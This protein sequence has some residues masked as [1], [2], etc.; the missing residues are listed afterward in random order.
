MVEKYA[1]A[2]R[3]M[4]LIFIDC[5]TRDQFSLYLGSR[6]LHQRLDQH[7]I[8]HTYEEYDSDHFLLRREQERKS[9]P[10]LI[11]ALSD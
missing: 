9:I 3:Q 11:Q 6:Q 2:L 1:A 5:G 7:N 4:R 8:P 10:L